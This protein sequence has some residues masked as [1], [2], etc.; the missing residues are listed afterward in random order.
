MNWQTFFTELKRRHVYRVA[1]AYAV[2][3][4]LV[5]QISTQVLPFFEIPNFGVRLV[6]IL[7]F[8]G[9]PIALMLAWIFDLTP[10]GLKRTEDVDPAVQ[11]AGKSHAWIYVPIVAALISIGL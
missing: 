11:S 4:W 8:A 9:L 3:G 5:V 10:E 7:I 6:V 1:V 2:V